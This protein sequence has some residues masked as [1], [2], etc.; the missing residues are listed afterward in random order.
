MKSSE[1]I[2]WN[3][4]NSLCHFTLVK[5]DY[6]KWTDKKC[7][8]TLNVKNRKAIWP[9]VLAA[10]QR[11]RVDVWKVWQEHVFSVNVNKFH[12]AFHF[13]TPKCFACWWRCGVRPLNIIITISISN[14]SAIFRKAKANRATDESKSWMMKSVYLKI[15]PFIKNVF[16]NNASFRLDIS[17]LWL[18][19]TFSNIWFIF[20]ENRNKLEK[21]Q[22]NRMKCCII[23][24]AMCSSDWWWQF[25]LALKHL[26]TNI[27]PHTNT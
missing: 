19:L 16:M 27:H 17:L 15:V 9:F 6:I 22:A 12:L 7:K 21:Y 5:I 25:T 8:V 23:Y 14:W 26:Q 13:V 3:I 11:A 24:V 2:T 18:V 1:K 10:L 20:V 4:V